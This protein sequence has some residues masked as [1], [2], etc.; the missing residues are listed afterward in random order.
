MS[1]IVQLA[2]LA[3]MV[4]AAAPPSI[5]MRLQISELANTVTAL[6]RDNAERH[7]VAE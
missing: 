2:E 6:Q 4:M 5:D 3:G 7:C 1:S